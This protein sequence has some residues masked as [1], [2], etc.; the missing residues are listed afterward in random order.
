MSRKEFVRRLAA[1]AG[2]RI[3]GASP[4]DI[5]GRNEACYRRVKVQG[6]PGFGESCIEGWWDCADLGQLFERILKSSIEGKVSVGW[7]VL[8]PCRRQW[9]TGR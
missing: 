7:P 5:Q 9:S 4:S 2:I 6:A 8:W 1:E 3:G